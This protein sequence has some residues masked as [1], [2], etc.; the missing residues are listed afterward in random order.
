MSAQPILVSVIIAVQNEGIDLQTTLESMKVSQV[1]FQYEVII[2]DE[3]SVDGCCDF[4]MNFKFDKPLRKLKGQSGVS[5]RQ[6][7]AS[8]ALGSY[9]I[10]CSPRLY[11]EDGWMEALL[12]PI[13]QGKADCSTPCFT[14]QGRLENLSRCE[15]QGDGLLA[16][17]YNF[18]S[19][20]EQGEI[21]WL[22]SDCFA[23]SAQTLKEL[24]GI[25]SGFYTKEIETAEFSLRAWLLGRVCY[26][27]PQICLTLV[28][29]HNYPPDS[30]AAYW[31]YDMITLACMHF[32]R[33]VSNRIRNIV[34]ESEREHAAVNLIREDIT[35]AREKYLEQRK[36][37]EEWFANRFGIQL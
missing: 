32:T 25:E 8:Y 30:R 37:G 21:P 19:V 14:A 15:L 24:G 5:S 7:G 18:P 9:I 27:V 13:Q 36:Y 1:S 31:G 16:S 23:V 12:E 17:I 6:L 33:E 3:G 11:F 10:F 26:F 35:E 2:V 22:S 34:L 4:L 29:R 20:T 28:F